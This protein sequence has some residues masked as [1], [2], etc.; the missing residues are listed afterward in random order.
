MAS[1]EELKHRIALT[2]LPGI[3]DVNAKK[4]I[5]YCGGVE[6]VF[7]EKRSVLEKIPSIGAIT[8][9]KI[10]PDSVMGRA[11]AEVE[12]IRKYQI[13]AWFG[14]TEQVRLEH[15]AQ[16]TDEDFLIAASAYSV[17]QGT[18]TD[19][20]KENTPALTVPEGALVGTGVQPSGRY[21]T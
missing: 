18:E 12:F 3:G 2:L 4:L 9:A 10:Q 14:N 6:A 20:M 17:Q 5:A 13:N 7:R 16:I 21:W 11:E 15:Y 8:A 1:D 19:C